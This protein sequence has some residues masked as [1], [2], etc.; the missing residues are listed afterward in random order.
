MWKYLLAWFPMIVLAIANGL[1]REK[2]ISGR[3][4]ELQAHQLSTFSLMMLF[5][6]YIWVLFK[7]WRPHS[8]Q[9]AILIGILWTLLTIIFEFL[10]GHFI[11][12]HDWQTLLKDYNIFKGRLW[13]LF[14]IW[15]GIAPYLIYELQK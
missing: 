14:L 15:V 12:G 4:N 2:I 1:F 7:F 10:F 3:F 6:V 9:Q 11:V 8:V 5:G 13:L